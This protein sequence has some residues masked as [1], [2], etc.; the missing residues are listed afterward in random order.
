MCTIST[1]SKLHAQTT[2][3][4]GPVIYVG[5]TCS[6]AE[7]EATHVITSSTSSTPEGAAFHTGTSSSTPECAAVY[8]GIVQTCSDFSCQEKTFAACSF[9][10]CLL[11]FENFLRSSNSCESHNAFFAE[12]CLSS[13]DFN[14]AT[15][16]LLKPEDFIVEG[17]PQ[18]EMH[19]EHDKSKTLSKQARNKTIKQ[20]INSGDAYHTEKTY[21]FKEARKTK[22]KP[23][24]NSSYCKARGLAC[25][26]FTEEQRTS[27]RN[28]YF[29]VGS[30]Q[31]QREWVARH[32]VSEPLKDS[33]RK[34]RN[35]QFYLPKGE[36]TVP[37]ACRVCK[38]MFLS[39]VGISDRQVRTV[40]NKLGSCN[41]LA[42]E[43]RGGRQMKQKDKQ[44][45]E[46]VQAHIDIFPKTESHYCRSSTSFQY[47]A[48]DL[49]VNK[50]YD[51]YIAEN[52]KPK[53]SRTLYGRLLHD[54]KLKFHK[55]KK[56]LCGI[57]ETYRMGNEQEKDKINAEYMRHINEKNKVREL[58]TE[59]KKQALLNP[60]TYQ[61][62]VYDLQ[63]VIYLPRS[64]RGTLFYK[65]RLSC[66][67]FTI[68]ELG[69]R[70][71]LCFLHH[72]GIAK[73]GANEIASNL[74]RYLQILDMQCKEEVDLFSDG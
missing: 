73:R 54:M 56:H 29:S 11:C 37:S 51:L 3:I 61:S 35:T 48:S 6:A 39:T 28:A 65:R 60:Q 8:T 4:S 9:C 25:K 55:P 32:I 70:E 14:N 23:K 44:L 22:Y 46:E 38:V 68:Y 43:Q 33:T 62:S 50:M 66:Y 21:S 40:I 27:I 12:T 18:T 7:T 26:H 63:Q 59:K 17:E 10:D 45:R 64:G 42:Q 34:K 67:D 41:T 24:C 15:T 1:G 72:E 36:D 71:G 2:S 74:Y 30:L 13:T 58:K 20:K 31:A 5:S 16:V 69:T 52:P 49:N 53:A 19:F 57:C 47:L